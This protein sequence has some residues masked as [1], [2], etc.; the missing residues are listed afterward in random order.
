MKQSDAKRLLA[1]SSIGQIGYIVLAVGAVLL[2]GNSG[3]PALRVLAV[4]AA[5]GALYHVLNHAIFKG[6]LFLTSGS[7]LYATGTKDLNKLGG[8]IKLMPVTA[9]V[10]GIASLSISGMPPTSGFAS[11]WSIITSSLLA[12]DATGFLVLFGIV[13]LFTSAVTL[14]CY[15]KFF[16][17]TFTSSGSEWNVDRK[18]REV[19]ASMLAPEARP[20]G[21]LPDPGALPGRLLRPHHDRP[22][23]GPKGSC[24]PTGSRRPG[25]RMSTRLPGH[26]AGRPRRDGR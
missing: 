15:V 24:W 11:K 2:L 14:A 7:I 16:G 23:G 19:P 8:L 25:I 6:L 10:A 26:P 4:V 3:E 17:M 22:R 5:V 9:V 1:Y 21:R 18:I 12:G 13:A 20:D